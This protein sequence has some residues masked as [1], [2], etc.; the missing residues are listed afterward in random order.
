MTFL[1]CSLAQIQ[2]KFEVFPRMGVAH[3]MRWSVLPA[4]PFHW[5]MGLCCLGPAIRADDSRR[6]A[7][8]HRGSMRAVSCMSA[9]YIHRT[10][11]LFSA[12]SASTSQLLHAYVSTFHLVITH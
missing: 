5:T 7:V 2:E 1:L 10:L 6:G 9:G 8:G 11:P 3:A 12:L 4:C